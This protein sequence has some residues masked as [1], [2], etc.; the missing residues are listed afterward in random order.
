MGRPIIQLPEDMVR[1]Q[2]LIFMLKPDVIGET[3]I[4]H[5]GSLIYYASLCK[6]L[7]K[8]RVIGVDIEIR[9]SNRTALEAH[10]L[11]PYITLIEGDS[12][13]PNTIDQ[14]KNMIRPG[15]SVLVL[16]DSNHSKAHVLAELNAYSPLVTIGSYIIAT[17]GIM[18]DL[19]GSPNAHDSWKWDNPQQAAQEF[20]E[21]NPNFVRNTPEFLFNESGN[22]ERITYWPHGSLKR[23][24]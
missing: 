2:E 22:Q 23:I 13:S 3:G 1:T 19:V 21:S 24:E 11:F 10:E 17:D 16:L 5:G 12:T 6:L 7:E 20:A 4:A 18:Q 9:P 8:G 15:E 14:V